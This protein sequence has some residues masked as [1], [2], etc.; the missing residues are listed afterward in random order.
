MNTHL[1]LLRLFLYIFWY[2]FVYI[3]VLM[4]SMWYLPVVFGIAQVALGQLHVTDGSWGVWVKT[5]ATKPQQS[6]MTRRPCV[7]FYWSTVAAGNITKYL[8]YG[9]F[10]RYVKFWIAHAPGCRERFPR[11]RLQRKP[12][13]SDHCMLRARAVMHVGITNPRWRGKRSRHSWRMPNPQIY[14]SDKRPIPQCASLQ[15]LQSM[16]YVPTILIKTHV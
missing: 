5:I 10:T 1:V 7:W 8:S 2:F 11:H 6:T 3:L 15:K 9:P 14:E 16:N 4:V 12:L 13:V